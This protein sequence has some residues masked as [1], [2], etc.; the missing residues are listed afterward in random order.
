MSLEV[1][2]FRRRF[3]LGVFLAATSLLAHPA[4][5][6]PREILIIRHAEKPLD[7][8]DFHLTPR[9]YSRAAALAPFFAANFDTPDFLFATARSSAS[10]RPVETLTPLASALHMTLDSGYAD[11]DYDAMARLIL[12]DP[13]YSGAMVI[14]CWHHGNIPALAKSLGV[15][16]PPGPWPDAVFDRVWRLRYSD[17]ASVS[18]E[19]LPQSILF[20]DSQE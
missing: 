6:Q 8:N 7:P 2:R 15:S 5:S 10:N 19:N 3:C 11:A 18:F 13:K 1:P 4:L 20:G 9:G 12:S 17:D 14:I 16:S